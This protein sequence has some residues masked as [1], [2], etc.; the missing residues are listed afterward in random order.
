MRSADESARDTRAGSA[1]GTNERG[2]ACLRLVRRSRVLGAEVRILTAETLLVTIATW[3]GVLPRWMPVVGMPHSCTSTRSSDG[4]SST[5]K[6][7]ARLC[8]EP[9]R[10]AETCRT[11]QDDGS[12]GRGGVRVVQKNRGARWGNTMG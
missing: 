1:S 4:F 7:G 3:S 12:R 6:T 9:L 2:G 10:H 11:R 5:S 8:P